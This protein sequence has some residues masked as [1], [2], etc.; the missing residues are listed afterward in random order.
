VADGRIVTVDTL[1]AWTRD[2]RTEDD[3][4]VGAA[5]LY[6]EAWV[7]NETARYWEAV[8]EATTASAR[9]YRPVERCLSTIDIHDCTEIVSVVENG[10]TLVEDLD[11]VVEPIDMLLPNGQPLAYTRLV[12]V[13]AHW[14]YDDVIPRVVVTAKWGQFE[15][16]PAVPEAIKFV[17]NADLEGRKINGGIVAV[18]EVGGLSERDAKT[19]RDTLRQYS[20]KKRVMFA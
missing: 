14:Y 2:Q 1:K 5:I 18:T 10:T 20:R 12:R 6:A 8:T 17:A 16:P 19:V 4:V 9:R 7:D 13:R 15:I 3:E 11:Y